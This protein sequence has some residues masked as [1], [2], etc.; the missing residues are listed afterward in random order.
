MPSACCPCAC[1][2]ARPSSVAG[3][4]LLVEGSY[5]T[6]DR[7][8]RQT[9]LDRVHSVTLLLA[10]F[11]FNDPLAGWARLP[12]PVPI[13]IFV[14]SVPQC[15]V[16]P[17]W[18]NEPAVSYASPLLRLVN[19]TTLIVLEHPTPNP[20]A[21]SP[22]SEAG[23]SWVDLTAYQDGRPQ[24]A[25][26]WD[27]LATVILSTALVEAPELFGR[28]SVTHHSLAGH[29]STRVI[30]DLVDLELEAN[31]EFD[32]Y[33]AADGFNELSWHN[34]AKADERR[35]LRAWVGSQEAKDALE[36]LILHSKCASPEALG[37]STFVDVASPEVH[38]LRKQIARGVWKGMDFAALEIGA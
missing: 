13:S 17:H 8:S 5:P 12:P 14:I 23:R 29:P 7:V 16:D 22:N 6:S 35:E 1:P 18:E 15:W 28:D 21:S 2:C 33:S 19:P 31:G 11:I 37:K 36:R 20:Y 32:V 34:F 25:P 27:R 24:S 9:R 38:L 4:Q 26:P 3:S 10:E 30:V